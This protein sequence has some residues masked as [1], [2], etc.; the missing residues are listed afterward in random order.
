MSALEVLNNHRFTVLFSG[1][2][3]STATLLWVYNNIR[4]SDWNVLY[5]EVTGN[6]H[7]LCTEYVYSV[8]SELS[9]NKRFIHAKTRDFYELADRWGPPLIGAYRWCLY[10]LKLK[11]FGEHSYRF[12]VDGVKRMDSK[13]RA[14]IQAVNVLKMSNRISVSPIFSWDERSVVKYIRECGFKLNPCYEIFG[15]SANCVFC[16]YHDQ[17]SIILTM[18]NNEWGERIRRMLN[19]H[20]EK[21]MKGSIGRQIYE[22]W[23]RHAWQKTL[24]CSKD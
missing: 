11:A 23:M 21:M 17:R 19:K 4:H 14:G 8:L 10:Q 7:P 13:V 12:T 22:R 9:L 2:K 15:N 5:V 1:G 18:N 24:S 6:T 3:D 16:P 20:R